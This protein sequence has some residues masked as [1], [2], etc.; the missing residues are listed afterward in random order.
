VI[1]DGLPD[2]MKRRTRLR[3][4]LAVLLS[5][6]ALFVLVWFRGHGVYERGLL[7]RDPKAAARKIILFQSGARWSIPSLAIDKLMG[8]ANV[9]YYKANYSKIVSNLVSSGHAAERAFIFHHG[10][11]SWKSFSAELDR[12]F[13]GEFFKCVFKTEE[14]T[15]VVVARPASMT[16]WEQL[17]RDYDKPQVAEA[18]R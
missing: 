1:W 14:A 17:V 9:A 6:A 5:G 11:Y 7:E 12:T 15:I 13:P 8:R 10:T 16:R 3:L 4:L 18:A 2:G